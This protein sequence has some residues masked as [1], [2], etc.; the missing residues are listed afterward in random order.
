MGWARASSKALVAA[1]AAAA[2]AI[3]K[4]SL[5]FN[6]GEAIRSIAIPEFSATYNLI[7]GLGEADF[8]LCRILPVAYSNLSWQAQSNGAPHR[9][10]RKV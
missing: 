3:C 7:C 10:A 6:M 9:Q 2:P 1:N 5:R 4:T 8:L